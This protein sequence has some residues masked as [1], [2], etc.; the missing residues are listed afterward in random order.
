M[1]KP[2]LIR[3]PQFDPTSG[4]IRVMYGLYG[5]LLAK[6]EIAYLNAKIDI[7]SIGIYPE[8]YHGN[9]MGA[10]TIV[11]YV[12]QTPGLMGTAD[13]DGIFRTGPSTEVIKQ[14]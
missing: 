2:Y 5:W 7:P 9:D 6:G 13:Q 14:T 10:K 4:G 1:R 8:I 11:R 12:L 3:T